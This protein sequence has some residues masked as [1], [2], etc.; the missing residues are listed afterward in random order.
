MILKYISDNSYRKTADIVNEITGLHLTGQAV[1]LVVQKVGYKL[2]EKEKLEQEKLEEDELELG[3][4]ENHV[5]FNELD[6]V[7]IKLQGKDK[8]EAI[9]KYKERN[10]E[11]VNVPKSVSKKEIKVVSIYEGFEKVSKKRIRLKNKKVFA[12]STRRCTLDN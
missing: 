2:K 8:K 1:W 4:E 12:K 7:Y 3:K 10:Q 9:K 6:G 5:L 11:C